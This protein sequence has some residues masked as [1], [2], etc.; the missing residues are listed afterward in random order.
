MQVARVGPLQVRGSGALRLVSIRGRAADVLPKS[1]SACGDMQAFE[2]CLSGSRA[3]FVVRADSE[4]GS[5]L[6][7]QG[8]PTFVTQERM[9]VGLPPEGW[10]GSFD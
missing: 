4:P 9:M 8:T 10:L 5:R 3:A 7:I 6:G 2:A 1:R